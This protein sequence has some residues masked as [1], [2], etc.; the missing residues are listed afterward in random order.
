MAQ[1][2]PELE[3]MIAEA[4]F[5]QVRTGAAPPWLRHARAVKQV[6]RVLE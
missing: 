5:D 3:R 4:D 1:A 6:D 2:V